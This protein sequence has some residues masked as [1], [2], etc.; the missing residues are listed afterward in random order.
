MI[1]TLE[2][3]K[4]RIEL[5]FV[6]QFVS[7]EDIYKFCKD[8]LKAE[9]GVVCVNPVNI[10]LV[11]RLLKSS[12]INISGNVGFPFGSH[13]TEVKV[14]EAKKAIEHGANQID[15]VINVGAL[16]SKE[17]N[18]VHNDILEV[19]NAV[20][21]FTVKAIIETWVL[22][23]NEK[24]RACKI[25]EKAGV[26]IVK[27]TTGVR[28]QYLKMVNKTPKGAI[29]KD[30]ILMRKVLNPRCK[31]KASGGIYE[32]DY[33]LTLLRAGAYQLGVSKG[34]QIIEEFVKKYGNSC[35]L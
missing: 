12:S 35:K 17:D 14:L 8:A 13:L 31:I 30:I 10:K 11:K 7:K 18:L 34:M 9:V 4:K 24:I 28:T 5:S 23:D 33:A 32:L 6:H 27:T 15:L 26:D 25:A 1:L 16:K 22:N 3:F 20:K 29:V 19:V 2:D 21:G